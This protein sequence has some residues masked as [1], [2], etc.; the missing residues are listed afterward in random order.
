MTPSHLGG[1]VT[2]VV[3]NGVA[4]GGSA[5]SAVSPGSNV[6][7][8]PAAAS[9]LTS[10]SWCNTMNPVEEKVCR[11]LKCGHDAHVPRAECGCY[12]CTCFAPV[13]RGPKVI[14]ADG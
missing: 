2:E 5:D 11:N 12:A 10:C 9:T 8:T 7:A 4:S 13:V 1:E 14:P 3:E 6:P